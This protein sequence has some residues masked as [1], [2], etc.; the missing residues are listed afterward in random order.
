MKKKSKTYSSN[1]HWV[2]FDSD[3]DSDLERGV[4]DY[5]LLQRGLHDLNL[6]SVDPSS[7]NDP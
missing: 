7:Q 6:N 1:V 3:F 4:V 5:H 2:D